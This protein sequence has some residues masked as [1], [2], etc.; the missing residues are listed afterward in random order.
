MQ[1]SPEVSEL[2]SLFRY[3]Q[4]FRS[5]YEVEG[6]QEVQ[7]PSGRVWSL[8]DLEYLYQVAARLLTPAQ[9]TAIKLFL[10]E[11]YRE[12]DAAEMMGVSRTNPIGMYAALGL[13]KLVEFINSGGVD[14]FR[15][16]RENWQADHARRVMDSLRHLAERIRKETEV[17]PDGCLHYLPTPRGHVPRLRL[18]S[19]SAVAGYVLVHPRQVL[20]VAEIGPIPDG[21]TLRQLYS[22]PDHRACH[23]ACV[24]YDHARLVRRP[25]NRKVFSWA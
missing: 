18:R 13:S 10:V 24:D 12:Q 3:L 8:W 20:F 4:E 16:E 9:Y 23:L 15:A 14:R 22:L 19:T 17:S 6:I 2:R 21:Y 1:A 7:T 11:D 25:S 5:L